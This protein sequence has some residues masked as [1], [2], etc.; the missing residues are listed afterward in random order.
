[1]IIFDSILGAD[2]YNNFDWK[3]ALYA[4]I[5]ILIITGSLCLVIPRVEKDRKTQGAMIQSIFR[6]NYLMLGIPMTLSVF[7]DS[8]LLAAATLMAFSVPLL[9]VLA[10]VVLET[11][12]GQ[13]PKVKEILIGVAR[14]PVVIAAVSAILLSTLRVTLPSVVGKAVSMMVPVATPLMLM[15]LGASFHFSETKKYIRQLAISVSSKLVIIPA[16]LIPLSVYLGYCGE[17]LMSLITMFAAPSAVSSYNM[18][19][20]MDSNHEFASQAVIYSTLFSAITMFALIF[21]MSE[22]GLLM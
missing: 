18:A 19:V 4:I 5:L 12:R 21:V 17:L 11:Y 20:I 10:V 3:Y 2:F 9:N 7:P 8:D 14:N 22:F 15:S 6:S 1:M 16:I 13:K